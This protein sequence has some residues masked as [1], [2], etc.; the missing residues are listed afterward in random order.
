VFILAAR[1]MAISVLDTILH[2]IRRSYDK[3]TPIRH[4]EGKQVTIILL[5]IG[6]TIVDQTLEGFEV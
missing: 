1:G 4:E 2:E 3:Y 6:Q 5:R